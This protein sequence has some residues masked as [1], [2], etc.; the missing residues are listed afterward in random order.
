ML[1]LI[2]IIIAIIIIIITIIVII[3]CGLIP[4][5][6]PVDEQTPRQCPLL[7]TAA[8]LR[9]WYPAQGSL[10]PWH[11]VSFASSLLCQYLDSATWLCI[12]HLLLLPANFSVLLSSWWLLLTHS[13][14]S[15]VALS[16]SMVGD[17]EQLCGSPIPSCQEP[18]LFITMLLR[19]REEGNLCPSRRLNPR[20]LLLGLLPLRD[21]SLPF[22]VA[23]TW[24]LTQGTPPWYTE[25]PFPNKCQTCWASAALGN[26]QKACNAI[27]TIGLIPF[28]FKCWIMMRSW[29]PI[30][31]F[32]H[33]VEIFWYQFTE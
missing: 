6:S 29:G 9:T 19:E 32:W 15:P 31:D 24:L 11:Q 4:A 2:I 22:Q 30:T 3:I 25:M 12:H 28:S 1:Q 10:Q 13:F 14:W 5:G 7:G 17:E 20:R 26:L 18:P 16:C 8:L 23:L 21:P 27:C 33:S